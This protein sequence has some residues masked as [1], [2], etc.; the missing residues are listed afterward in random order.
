MKKL[1]WSYGG[2]RQ[3]A[4]IAVLI[5][6]GILPR[7]D[8]SCIA[9]TGHERRTTWKYL[10]QTIRPL[11]KSVGVKIEVIPRS[12]CRVGYYGPEGITLVGAYTQE[13]KLP[14]YCSGEWKRDT[15]ERWLRHRGVEQCDSIIGY[16]LNEQER[17]GKDHRKWCH[18]I[19]PLVEMGINL[20]SCQAIV[21]KAG[22]P[23][24]PKSRCYD[25]PEQSDDEWTEVKEDEADW[26]RALATEAEINEMDPRQK[27]LYLW[28]G[29]TPLAMA[30]FTRGQPLLWPAR[31][32]EG[33]GCFT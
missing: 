28:S 21:E 17:I 8:I 32:C 26:N 12:F 22:L 14:R 31:K 10:G 3:S 19:Y 4:A 5:A 30:D 24:A 15:V 9:N 7:P 33:Q 25:C 27:G 1:V 16:S 29:R 18:Y 11:L 13:G 2:G 6:K 23:P 20:A